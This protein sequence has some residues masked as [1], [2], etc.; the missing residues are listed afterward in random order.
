ME[1][2]ELNKM[3]DETVVE[4]EKFLCNQLTP[5]QVALHEDIVY[6]NIYSMDPEHQNEHCVNQAIDAL[7]RCRVVLEFGDKIIA[8]I[9]PIYDG[10][11]FGIN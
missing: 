4:I 9:K 1:P 8:P 5:A 7:G 11:V 6:L 3:I 10:M 2:Q